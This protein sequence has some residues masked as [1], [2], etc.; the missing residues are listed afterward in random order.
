M[1]YKNR[2]VG[3]GEANPAELMPNPQNWRKHPTQQQVAMRQTLE[4]VGWIQEVIV[5]KTTGRL[6][7]GH[8]RVETA[9]RNKEQRIPVKYVELS[10]D[11]ERVAL[12]TFDPVGAMA[13]TDAAVLEAL[14]Q[15][16]EMDF[17]FDTFKAVTDTEPK[18]KHTKEQLEE[19]PEPPKKPKTQ[20]GDVYRLGDHV[21]MCGDSTNP[22]NI[23][24]IVEVG[25]GLPIDMMLTDPPYCSGGFQ[26][27]D[28]NVGSIGT[29]RDVKI[30]NDRLSTRGYIALIKSVLEAV[31]IISLT[32]IFTDWRMWVNL[33][34][35]V[36]SSGYAVRAMIVWDKGS[37]G[38][39]WGWR[40]Q[41]EL[42]MFASRSACK[43]DG[44][45][46][47]G[48]V[49]SCKRTGNPLHP[50]QK[51]VELLQ[52]VLEVTDFAPVVYDPFGGS[53][54]T[55]IACEE[56]GRKCRMMELA[57]E[58]CDVIV[59]RWEKLTG[60]KAEKVTA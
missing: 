45:K 51:P 13:E 26:E 6:I 56:V 8:L 57:P 53:G 31:G 32:Y 44:K 41:H 40:P 10:E 15:S 49:I 27:A 36:E 7:D 11:E 28:R 37:M 58:Y 39:G 48:N 50:T 34:D 59:E 1:N 2:I 42:M 9:L 18:E 47:A 3:S 25:G 14:Q 12:A 21:L 20:R 29:D 35:A 52:K 30:L 60:K 5:N 4:A 54:S 22:D 43:F 38:M 46:S 17:D 33:F 23:R 19:T 16:V 24:K 55:L